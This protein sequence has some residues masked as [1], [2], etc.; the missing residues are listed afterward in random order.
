MGC[1]SGNTFQLS[2]VDRG[3]LAAMGEGGDRL[4]D[5]N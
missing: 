1:F 4:L 3:L 5:L 2:G